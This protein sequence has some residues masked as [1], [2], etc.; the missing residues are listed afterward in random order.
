[1]PRR[2]A[3]KVGAA[4]VA[5]MVATPGGCARTTRR[6]GADSPPNCRFLAG[7]C[8]APGPTSTIGRTCGVGRWRSSTCRTLLVDRDR[9]SYP[10]RGMWP[11][12]RRRLNELS[13]SRFSFVGEQ[14]GPPERELKEQCRPVLAR[15]PDA[16]RAYLCRVRYEGEPN[17]H[18]ALCI[19]GRQ[20]RRLTKKIAKTLNR[21]SK[22][23]ASM[24]IMFVPPNAAREREAQAVC[25]AFYESR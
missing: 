1:V 10:P 24:D 15:Y 25:A 2:S 12:S 17:D 5:G 19:A 4:L 13:L 16:L 23:R 11:F 7:R 14:D 21:L 18:V 9:V 3:V 22:G 20:N 6:R 8:R